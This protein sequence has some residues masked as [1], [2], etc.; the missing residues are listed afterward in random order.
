MRWEWLTG[1]RGC[2]K[3]RVSARTG[4]DVSRLPPDG[5]RTGGDGFSFSCLPCAA[6]LGFIS[7]VL[8]AYLHRVATGEVLELAPVSILGRSLECQI[9]VS[10]PRVSRRHAMIRKQEGGF[11]LFDLG[12]FNGSYLNGARVTAVRKLNNGDIITF[13]D[14]EFRYAQVGETP[15]PVVTAEN[16]DGSTIAHVSHNPVIIIVSDVKGF[17]ALSEA[18]EADELAQIIGSWYADCERVLSEVGATV[19]K[20][21]GDCVLA[22]WTAVE[23][24]TLRAALHA[25][26]QLLASCERIYGVRPDV[27]E[28]IGRR[29][30]VG[31]AL[32]A[33]KV[34]YGGMSRSEFTLV[35]DP[36]NVAFRFESLTRELGRSVVISGDFVR[37]MPSLR[38]YCKSHGVQ[39]VRGRTQSLEAF[40]LN[41][42][43]A[44]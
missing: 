23:P 37:E 33:G 21:I 18:V 12:S 31:V 42:F 32:H 4:V 16:L 35:G 43:P 29:F 9:I 6:E 8:N 7:P 15:K 30:E 22:Y 14:H 28:R 3:D 34:A 26:E 13:A 44:G 17:T 24:A 38:P 2:V 36:V 40:S 1:G 27:F 11:H 19:D 25:A 39:V 20:F 41:E 5:W 10:D